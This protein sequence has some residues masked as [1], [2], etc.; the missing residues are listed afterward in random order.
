D[1][2]EAV[3]AV[4]EPQLTARGLRFEIWA[5]PSLRLRGDSE[6][7]QQILINL[8][9][10]AGKFTEPGGTVALSAGVRDGTG[11]VGAADTRVGRPGDRR[12]T[13]FDPFVQVHRNLKQ[14]IEGTGLGLAISRDLARGMGGDLEVESEEGKGSTFTLTLPAV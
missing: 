14:N 4:V 12:A 10:N 1:A 11:A 2:V 13:I 5:A 3:R 8:L 6:K 9:S 7:I